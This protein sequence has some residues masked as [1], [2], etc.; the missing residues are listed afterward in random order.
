MAGM[1]RINVDKIVWWKIA[2]C[3]EDMRDVNF[4]EQLA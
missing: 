3:H 4:R 1:M 2:I